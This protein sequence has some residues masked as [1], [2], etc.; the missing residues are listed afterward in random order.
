M[1]KELNATY[2]HKFIGSSGK[3]YPKKISGEAV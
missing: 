1:T 3:C 2:E